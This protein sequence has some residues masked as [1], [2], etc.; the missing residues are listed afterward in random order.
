MSVERARERER[1]REG[2]RAGNINLCVPETRADL[3]RRPISDH[4]VCISG[5]MPMTVVRFFRV[6]RLVLRAREFEL[7]FMQRD[8][9][10]PRKLCK[11]RKKDHDKVGLAIGEGG[12]AWPVFFTQVTISL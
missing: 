1:E 3:K 12:V 8:V 7:E 10:R 4:N 2:R 6:S 11:E 5:R 9:R